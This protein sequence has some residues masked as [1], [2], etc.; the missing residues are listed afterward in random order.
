MM[1]PK[2]VPRPLKREFIKRYVLR[3]RAAFRQQVRQHEV[4]EARWH[5]L[6]KH[7]LELLKARSER[8]FQESNTLQPPP[9]PVFR[10][11]PPMHEL[12]AM[13]TQASK[14]YV[15][16]KLRGATMSGM[17]M[18]GGIDSFDSSAHGHYAPRRASFAVPPAS[19]ASPLSSGGSYSSSSGGS[20]FDSAPS[21]KAPSAA[22]SPSHA[23]LHH[24][25]KPLV[26]SESAKSWHGQPHML[27]PTFE[28][29]VE[30]EQEDEQE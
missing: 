14:Q 15:L 11:L 17:G 23:H 30:E 9:K 12:D 21:S 10:L 29:T 27:E 2:R 8:G 26:G 25:L 1:A 18:G 24:P 7:E 28:R 3:K 19:F 13:I 5:D 16:S 6:H 20:Y 22:P 4:L